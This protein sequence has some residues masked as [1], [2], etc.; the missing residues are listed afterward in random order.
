LVYVWKKKKEI[1]TIFLTERFPPNYIAQ[2]NIAAY[3]PRAY[4]SAFRLWK[5][6]RRLRVQPFADN[7]GGI[8]QSF[9]NGHTKLT[10]YIPMFDIGVGLEK[11]KEIETI[12][13]TEIFPPNL[14]SPAKHCGVSATR[15]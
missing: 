3:Q 2:R 14:Y 11:N 9:I 10:I 13:F 12:F 6:S 5:F 7:L 15:Y 8:N 1:E 4:S